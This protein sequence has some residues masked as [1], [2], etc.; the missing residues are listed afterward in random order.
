MTWSHTLSPKGSPCKLLLVEA[1]Y[2]WGVQA[3]H[4]QKT[5]RPDQGLE[6]SRPARD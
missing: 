6:P 2:S 1:G 3:G 4:G 5:C